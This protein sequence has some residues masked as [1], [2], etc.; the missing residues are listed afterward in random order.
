MLNIFSVYDSK[1]EAFTQPFFSAT[2][3]TAIRSFEQAA[4]D[5]EHHF[6][7]HAADYTLFHL[8]SF[9]ETSGEFEI[10]P[11]KVN[12]GLAINFIKETPVTHGN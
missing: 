5:Q 9:E 11:A 3:G 8:G 4:N 12:L 7:K 6:N 1:A 10:L 2:S